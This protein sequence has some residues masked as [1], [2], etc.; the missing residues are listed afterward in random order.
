M[1]P[2]ALTPETET[3]GPTQLGE[4]KTRLH[5]SKSENGEN[6]ASVQLVVFPQDLLF[7]DVNLPISQAQFLPRAWPRMTQNARGVPGNDSFS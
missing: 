2:G 5:V 1:S 3:A 4:K 6:T 7:V